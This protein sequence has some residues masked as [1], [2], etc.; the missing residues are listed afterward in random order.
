MKYIAL[1]MLIALTLGLPT[2]NIQHHL[3]LPNLDRNKITSS[4]IINTS[5][6]FYHKITHIRLNTELKGN[7]TQKDVFKIL[8]DASE[9]DII[10][11]NLA[12]YGGDAMTLF[13]LKDDI[14]K[15]K[16]H[17][18]MDVESPVFSAHAYL[19]TSGD[20]LIMSPLSFMMFHT[21]SGYGTNCAEQTGT[22]R[23]VSNVEHCQ[24]LQDAMDKL[25]YDLVMNT[26]I[27][28]LNEQL[29]ILTGHDIYISAD[30]YNKR[31]VNHDLSQYH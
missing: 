7:N 21:I 8:E 18:I 27:L 29:L 12:G 28:T 26:P 4:E 15:S 11:F 16:A 10:V 1:L 20:E 13:Q 22:D 5:F 24:A 19:A 23:T 14:K 31:K 6:P 30:E 2:V 25:A 9:G 3:N 17:I